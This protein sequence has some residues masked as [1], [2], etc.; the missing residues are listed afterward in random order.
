MTYG[1]VDLLCMLAD[2][3][4]SE[5]GMVFQEVTS[6]CFRKQMSESKSD[7]IPDIQSNF[8]LGVLALSCS[9]VSVYNFSENLS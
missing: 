3:V 6:V 1:I 4:K 8:N 2:F 9:Y 5:N 7:Y